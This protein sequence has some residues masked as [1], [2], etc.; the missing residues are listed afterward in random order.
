[1]ST[2]AWTH[3]PDIAPRPPLARQCAWCHRVHQ[4]HGWRDMGF[5]ENVYAVTLYGRP[6]QVSHG[7]CPECRA[8]VDTGDVA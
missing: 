7:I 1:M 8:R 6:H 5:V 4:E 2:Y 3:Q